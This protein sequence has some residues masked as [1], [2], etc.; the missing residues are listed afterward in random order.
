MQGYYQWMLRFESLHCLRKSITQALDHLEE[1]EID[2]GNPL[3][4][5]EVA[6]LNI[7]LKNSLEVAEKFRDSGRCEVRA[8]LFAFGALLLIIQNVRDRMVCLSGFIQQIGNR[9]LQ[10]ICPEPGRLVFRYETKPGAKKLENVGGLGDQELAG[11][12]KRRRVGRMF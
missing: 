6:G 5:E 2:V 11:F 7:N 12:Q 1:R 9:Q 3:A 10:L 8:A 4:E